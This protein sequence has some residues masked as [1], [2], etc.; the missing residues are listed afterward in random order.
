MDINTTSPDPPANMT[1]NQLELY[2][3]EGPKQQ[4]RCVRCSNK[5]SGNQC[6]DCETGTF[7]GSDDHR[8]PCRP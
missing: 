2:L 8:D 5:T 3:G 6:E 1:I 4:A 7:R